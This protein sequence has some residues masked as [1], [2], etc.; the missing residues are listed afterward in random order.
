MG[1]PLLFHH[2]L[3]V[4]FWLCRVFFAMH[5]L[6]LVAANGLLSTCGTGASRGR[7]AD[8]ELWG[9]R[10]S[11]VGAHWLSCSMACGIFL[12]QGS[13]PCPLDWQVD[14]QPLDH[15]GILRTFLFNNTCYNYILLQSIKNTKLGWVLVQ[16][17]VCLLCLV[18]K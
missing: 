13:S 8:H 4:Y 9:T 2:L 5:R 17:S 6:S 14:S 16:F 10:A 11:V 1:F 7:V 18:L 3:F 15:Q 12:D